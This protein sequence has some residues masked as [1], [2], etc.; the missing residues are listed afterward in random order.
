MTPSRQPLGAL[1]WESRALA[2]ERD[3]ADGGFE[4]R[5]EGGRPS[6]E[7]SFV[8]DEPLHSDRVGTQLY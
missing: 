6:Q 5:P 4:S 3:K 1:R 7:K 2:K 8:F